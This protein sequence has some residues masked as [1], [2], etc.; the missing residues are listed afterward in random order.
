MALFREVKPGDTLR[1]GDTT[2][3]VDRKSGQTT[4]L[5]ID[6]P[7]K[8]QQTKAGQAPAASTPAVTA[9]PKPTLFRSGS[10]D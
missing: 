1:I 7:L 5:R 9:A 10:S 2:I 4:R 3:V 8:I 6:T